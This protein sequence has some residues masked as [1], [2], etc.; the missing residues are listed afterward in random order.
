MKRQLLLTSAAAALALSLSPVSAQVQ[1]DRDVNRD[2]ASPQA[3]QQD[4]KST[5]AERNSKNERAAPEN[6]ASKK[7]DASNSRAASD[8]S[9]LPDKSKTSATTGEARR[10]SDLAADRA[11]QS[12]AKSDTRNAGDT[13]RSTDPQRSTTGAAEKSEPSKA[14]PAESTNERSAPTRERSSVN[15]DRDRS[16]NQSKP[17]GET[18]TRVSATLNADA[19]TRLHS[20]LAKISVKPVR[21]VNFSISVGTVVPRT[22]T[23]RPLPT[24]VVEI[25]PQYR[26]YDFF[27]VREEIVIVEPRTHEIVDVIERSGPSH[28]RAESRS[29]RKLSLSKHQREIIHKHASRRHVTTGTTTRVEEIEVGRPLPESVEVETFP[30]DVYR[31]VPEVRSYRYIRRNDNIYL[32]DPGDRRVIEEID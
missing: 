9:A 15:S 24:T 28:A 22:V 21:N 31:E 32:V 17:S 23:L 5:R 10:D 12:D 2:Q 25:V 6:S 14:E 18:R 29:T 3:Q 11:R 13:R 1:R 20:A 26:G 19:K 30:D 8:K 7:D 16:Q 27:V 4:Q